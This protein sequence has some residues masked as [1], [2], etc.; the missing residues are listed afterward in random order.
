[1]ATTQK[2][3]DIL[4][5][6]KEELGIRLS[7]MTIVEATHSDGFSYLSV[8]ED[9]TPTTGEAVVIIKVRPMEWGV[10]TDVLGHTQ[11]VHVPTVIQFCTEKNYASTNDTIADNLTLSGSTSEEVLLAALATCLSKNCVFEWYVTAYGTVPAIGEI[12]GTPTATY[13]NLYWNFQKAQ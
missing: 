6:I 9:S 1:M 3:L 4:R 13:K 11:Q 8:Q 2:A 7:A 10:V 5:D 12:T